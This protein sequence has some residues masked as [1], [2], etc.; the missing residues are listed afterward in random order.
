MLCK[1][2]LKKLAKFGADSPLMTLV[3]RSFL[4]SFFAFSLMCWYVSLN[5]KHRGDQG[6]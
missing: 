5:L 1:K 6:L 3:Y 2:C 4:E